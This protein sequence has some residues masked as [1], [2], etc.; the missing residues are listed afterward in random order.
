MNGTCW[1][2]PILRPGRHRAVG[3]WMNSS[4]VSATAGERKGNASQA[5]GEGGRFSDP[6]E[7]AF[8]T[9]GLLRGAG[10]SRDA[11]RVVAAGGAGAPSQR[12][13]GGCGGQRWGPAWRGW[14][15]GCGSGDP[16]VRRA[17]PRAP[18]TAHCGCEAS[19]GGTEQAQGAQPLPPA[20]NPSST[21]GGELQAWVGAFFDPYTTP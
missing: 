2:L 8:P 10:L 1:T 11:Q 12:G 13:Q 7:I 16:F 20:Q 6:P 15:A 19:G 21:S 5:L 18:L 14:G 9:R 17:A 3:S 4:N